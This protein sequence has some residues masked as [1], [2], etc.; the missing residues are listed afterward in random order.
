MAKAPFHSTERSSWGVSTSGYSLARAPWSIANHGRSS[1]STWLHRTQPIPPYAVPEDQVL[2]NLPAPRSVPVTQVADAVIASRRFLVVLDDDPTGTQ[3]VAGVPVLTSWG[4]EDIRWAFQQGSS[5]FYV[6]TNTRGLGQQEMKVRNEE[7]VASLVAGA[8]PLGASFV[9]A[10]RSDSTLRGHFP[11]E[12]E[13]L[14]AALVAHGLPPTDGVL[15]APAYIEAGR[16]TVG[17]VHWART[18]DGLLPVGSS[19]SALDATFGY[20]SSDLR[21]YV[22]EKANGRWRAQDVA[23]ITLE[24]IRVGGPEAVA[25]TLLD[26]RGGRVAAIDAVS[27]DDLRVVALGAMAAEAEGSTLIY[28][29]GPSFVRCRAGLAARPPLEASDLATIGSGP[30]RGRGGLVIVGSHVPRS[31]RQLSAL[32][33]PGD[34]RHV[35]VEVPQVLSAA[36]RPAAIKQAAEDTIGAL[37]RGDVVVS[38]S[39]QFVSG[40]GPEA[41]LAI[42]QAVSSALVAVV[43]TVLS[44]T[45]PAWLVAKGGITSSDMATEALGMHRAWAKGTLLPGIISL[46][47]PVDGICPALPYVVFAGNVGDDDALVAV[48]KKLRNG[49]PRG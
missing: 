24:D 6:L 18:P 28:R 45:A 7:V 12:V 26:L 38:T 10:S 35:K 13:V 27:D 25:S 41:S 17:S 48:V 49:T 19:E 11:M 14:S 1:L 22:A 5:T 8:R 15:L 40:D 23:S 20:R 16:V 42:A 32:L 2:A 47:E 46:W 31:S 37:G 3:S 43:K 4:V 33:K 30:R 34:I 21:H 44:Q 39:R 9:L 36:L 29:V